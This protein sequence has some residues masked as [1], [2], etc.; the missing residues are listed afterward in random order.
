MRSLNKKRAKN[1]IAKMK[2]FGTLRGHSIGRVVRDFPQPFPT[3]HKGDFV[4]I[5]EGG[6]RMW[7]AEIP[8]TL[9]DIDMNKTGYMTT[10]CTTINVPKNLIA[11]I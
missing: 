10:I 7:T 2:E 8:K 9:E 11:K 5:R 4:I 3:Y 1:C 6:D